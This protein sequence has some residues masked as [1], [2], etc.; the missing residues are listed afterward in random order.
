MKLHKHKIYFLLHAIYAFLLIFF[1]MAAVDFPLDTPLL[2]I[3]GASAICASIFIL[4]RGIDNPAASYKNI[5]LGYLVAF[6]VGIIFHELNMKL[7]DNKV[8]SEL[9]FFFECLYALAV[10][11]V[12][13]LFFIFKINHP[14]AVGMTLGLVIEHWFPGSLLVFC[15]A[16]FGLV[17]FRFLLSRYPIEKLS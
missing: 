8:L 16:I 6:L 5:I 3:I 4:L 12:I 13:T 11:I 1:M 9:P 17:V 7:N 14:P 10:L 2:G 15:L